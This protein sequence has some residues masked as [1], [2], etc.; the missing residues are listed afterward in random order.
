M[1]EGEGGD[2][3][4]ELPETRDREGE[5]TDEEQMVVAGKN[6]HDPWRT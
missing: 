5:C 4:K 6:V 3:F 2:G 1:S